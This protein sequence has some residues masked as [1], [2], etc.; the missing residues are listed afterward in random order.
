MSA[1]KPFFISDKEISLFDS[2]NEELIDEMVGQSVDIYKIDTQHT[3]DNIYGGQ[4]QNTL[5][6]GL[7]LTV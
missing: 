1:T 4:R 6:L 5:M 3:K 2:M 7:G